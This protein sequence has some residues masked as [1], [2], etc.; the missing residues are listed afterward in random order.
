MTTIPA[1]KA[2]SVPLARAA[3]LPSAYYLDPA[4]LELEKERI[5]GR[6]WQL[7]ARTDDLQRPGDFVPVTVLDEPIVL[8]RGL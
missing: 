6:T 4:Y 2:P 1:P 5:F 3:T 7:V 8:T